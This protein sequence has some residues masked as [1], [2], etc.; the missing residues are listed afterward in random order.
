VIDVADV[1][2]DLL[3]AYGLSYRSTA[4][5]FVRVDDAAA[6]RAWLRGVLGRVTTAEP[7]SDG[8]PATT[9]NL[10]LTRS[11]LEALGV[12]PAYVATFVEE[13]RAG[14]AARARLLGDGDPA[15]WDS[16]LGSGR[17][18]VLVT[19][20]ARSADALEGELRVLRDG[21]AQ[22]GGLAIA[23]EQATH[24]LPE[25]REHFGFA[26]GFAQPALDGAGEEKVRG[27]GVP[28]EDGGWRPLASGE[29]LL[30]QPDEETRAD[31]RRR[32]PEAPAHPLGRN[33]TYMVWRKLHQDVASFRTTLREAARA[34]EA[35]DE[36]KLA[37][38]VVGRWRDATPLVL[39]PDAPAP[40][41]RAAAPGANDFRYAG[42]D[43]DGRRCPLGAHIRRANPR[44]ALD[45]GAKLSFRHRMIRRGMPYGPP[46]PA[47]ATEDDGQERGL[48]F[49]CLVASIAR[50][51]ES[52]QVQ[53]LR[54]G[55][56]FGL[57]A[58]TDFLMGDAEGRGKMTV[59]G[60]PPFFLAPQR[61]FVTMRGGEYLFV[62][63]I[64]ALSAIAEGLPAAPLPR[65]LAG[66]PDVAGVEH[67]M[68]EVADP[69]GRVRL[70]V[71]EAGRGEPLLLL[72][73]WP[74]HWA[75][76]RDVIPRLADA[77]RLVM[78]D[79]RGFGWS[80]A[81]GHGYDPETFAAD[82]LALL[83][84]LGH[85]R[86]AVVGHDWGGFAALLLALRHPER[87]SRLLVCNAPQPW[88]RLSWSL[89]LGAR[90]AWYVLVLAAPGLGPWLIADG[91][92]PRWLLA[93]GGT[94]VPAPAA[95]RGYAERLRDP[96]RAEASSQLYRAY[97]ALVVN[98]VLRRRY[99]RLRLSVPTRVLFGRDDAYIPLEYLTGV[100]AHADDIDVE[101][102]PGCGHWTPEE[103]SDLV[104]D[105]ARS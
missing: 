34:Y 12:P 93:R 50:Q 55:N 30:G 1:Q 80:E 83:D 18:H 14:M 44:D 65:E 98:A 102:I 10:A 9:L 49:V 27:G 29:F 26:D 103:R 22:A 101:L 5:V 84:A 90:R 19:I 62:P 76:W 38:K 91:R 88:A 15:G 46:L 51:F 21:L 89:V 33:G 53:W 52:V 47:E 20:N 39:A 72:H 28:A 77:H 35:G 75:S 79:H 25:A 40:G 13:F 42:A 96:A 6:G 104:A 70:H 99:D 74:E 7:W 64:A 8:K 68:V 61:P 58:D 43:P 67:R 31:P 24:A 32:L 16:G 71:A 4:Y 92:F 81:P 63:G 2:G 36:E 69:A 60:D 94:D 41:F 86:V 82:A 11:G 87:V 17:A 85:E 56:I 45:P 3:R 100:E 48:V 97:L 23:Y 73:G 57:G 105:R 66:M 54:D 37:A 59:H 78:P 95:V